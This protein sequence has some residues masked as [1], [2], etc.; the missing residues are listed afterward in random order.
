MTQTL[1]KIAALAALW[2]GPAA[3][4]CLTAAD[5]AR[6]ILFERQGAGTGSAIAAGDGVVQV[7]YDAARDG[8]TDLRNMAQG[9]YETTI[10]TVAAP[11]DVVGAWS[12]RTDTLRHAGRF[13]AP[14]AGSSW[15]TAVT[16]NWDIADFTGTPRSGRD[17]ATA[18]YAFLAPMDVTVSGCGYQVIPIE[19]RLT[20]DGFDY[21]TRFAYFPALGVALET[22]VTDHVTGTQ[23]TNGI[24]GMTA[25]R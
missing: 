23:R 8:Y 11:P 14:E 22:R 12:E 4:Q 17:R 18:A 21:T 20:G 5:L 25:V 1:V 24:I 7:N 10:L 6:G 19:R 16:R 9:V 3:A 13:P 15:E 2:A